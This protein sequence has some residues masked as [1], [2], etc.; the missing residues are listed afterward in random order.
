MDKVYINKRSTERIPYGFMKHERYSV[1]AKEELEIAKRM[2]TL[3]TRV[4][5]KR[6]EVSA[7]VG[8][9]VCKECSGFLVEKSVSTSGSTEC[10]AIWYQR[11]QKTF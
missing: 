11:G 6:M 8:I 7:L 5:G 10:G 3:N 1:I 2:L 9:A 4:V